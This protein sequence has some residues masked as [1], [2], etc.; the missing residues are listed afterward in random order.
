MLLRHR[1]KQG[2]ILNSV[3]AIIT[4]DLYILYHILEG[5]KIFLRRSFRKIVPLCTVSI[6][7]RFMMVR[8]RYAK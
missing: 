3:H 4:R 6:Q 2:L 5:Q 7:E 8:L 1:T